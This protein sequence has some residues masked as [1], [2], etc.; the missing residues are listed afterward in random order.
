MTVG[1]GCSKTCPA[2]VLHVSLYWNQSPELK[3]GKPCAHCRMQSFLL[4]QSK[5]NKS[6]QKQQT[7]PLII[8]FLLLL[9]SSSLFRGVRIPGSHFKQEVDLPNPVTFFFNCINYTGITTPESIP[10]ICGKWSS[11][12]PH[13][14]TLNIPHIMNTMNVMRGGPRSKSPS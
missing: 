9:F 4:S 13:T 10:M 2:L 8:M 6:K 11:L 14:E 12:S 1:W 3:H 5:Q 7:K